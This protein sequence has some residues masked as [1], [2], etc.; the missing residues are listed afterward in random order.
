M[1]NN[2]NRSILAEFL[3]ASTLGAIDRPRV[4][5]GAV[6][7][8]YQSKGIEIK[9][10][11]Y[12]QSWKQDRLSIPRFDIAKKLGW[13]AET[14]TVA[15]Q[16]TRSAD[17]YVFCLYPETDPARVN[18]LDANAWE[19]Y[20]L[21]TKKIEQELRDQ[22]SIGL[23]GLQAMCDPVEYHTLKDRVDQVLASV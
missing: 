17:C 2:R 19:F 10:A 18:V 3:V 21:S 5:W 20:V 23:K 7:L 22:K 14:N 8:H 15:S 13:D 4:E 16:P 9:S 12:L 11:A 1:L 6:D